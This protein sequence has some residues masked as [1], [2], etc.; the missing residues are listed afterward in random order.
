MLIIM[1]LLIIHEKFIT[2]KDFKQLIPKIR[3]FFLLIF[4]NI[5]IACAQQI[6][7][8]GNTRLFKIGEGWA[9][10]S[11]NANILR[12]N[13]VT[14]YHNT[15]YVAYYN[16]DQ[17]LVLA[18]RLIGSDKWQI[19]ISQYQGN[20][21]DA[22]RIISIAVDGD[23]YL[24]VSWD[25]HVNGLRYCKSITPGS[26]ELTEELPMTG[27][28]E[29]N[30]TYPEFYK[31]KNGDLLFLYRDGS[32]GNG[33]LVLN[34]Y[35]VREKKWMQIQNGWINGE[36]QR[37]PYWEMTVDK[38]GII[39][40]MWVWRESP[41]VA[42]NHDLAYAKSRDGGVTWERSD[43]QKYDLPITEK[44]AEYAAR[45]PENSDLINTTSIAAG[46][47]GDV[48][49]VH[50]WRTADSAVPQNR[51]VYLKNGRWNTQQI[52]DR[53]T[54]FSLSGGGTKRIPV[55][56]PQLIVRTVKSIVQ[57][58]I[59]Y[60][61]AEQGDRITVTMCSDI[62]KGKWETKCLSKQSIDM[63]E[64]SYDTDLWLKRGIIDLFVQK[65]EQGDAETTNNLSPQVISLLEWK[66][67]W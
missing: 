17:K 38:Y 29:A 34:R 35:D 4:L 42:S 15:Q 22:H 2:M 61:D 67:S 48:Y 6:P 53:K 20:A 39:H 41:D 40:I 32:S 47:S 49:D 45:I 5:N 55:S 51:L 11:V 13:S 46:D 52:S 7:A 27:L 36:K 23:G 10:N 1:A 9:K 63:W 33:N 3:I 65:V 60:R 25:H 28:N 50:Y 44:T 24:H 14:S 43:N 58:A 18:K 12:R 8:A 37:S 19:K 26:L 54:S 59:I 16:A 64:P 31:L 62:S 30:V 56:R 21:N 57:A 66:P